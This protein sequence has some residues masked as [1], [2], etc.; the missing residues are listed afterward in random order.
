MYKIIVCFLFFNV[1]T[2]ANALNC[3]KAKLSYLV[4]RAAANEE[5][6]AVKMALELGA[7]PDGVSEKETVEC[8]GG[9]PVSPPVLH[10]VQ[11]KD[12][13]ILKLLLE[14]G[15]S[16]NAWCCDSSAM[17]IARDIKNTK[18]IELLNK[19]DNQTH[20]K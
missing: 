13:S 9:L 3:E 20:N 14:A 16:P 4:E 12:V 19:Y 10:A 11:Y 8:F 15:A 6:A 17:Q 2:N 18:A 7:D 1:C 5:E